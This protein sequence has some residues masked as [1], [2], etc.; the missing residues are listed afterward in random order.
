VLLHVRVAPVQGSFQVP[1][2][3]AGH[4]FAGVQQVAWSAFE[5]CSPV[6][7]F[8]AQSTDCPVHGSVKVPQ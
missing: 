3:F 7:Q 4:A 2:A 8:V 6:S 1:Q 5:H